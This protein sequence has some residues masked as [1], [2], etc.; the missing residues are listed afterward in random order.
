MTLSERI[1]AFAVLGDK[2]GNIST[3]EMTEYA[4]RAQS[5]NQWFTE[6]NVKRA[7]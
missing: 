6:D 7:F 4:Y 5:E 2:I 1:E 3:E